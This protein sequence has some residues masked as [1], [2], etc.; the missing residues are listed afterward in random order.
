MAPRHSRGLW[1]I[2]LL[3]WHTTLA[4]QQVRGRAAQAAPPANRRSPMRHG[5]LRGARRFGAA[6]RPCPAA[7]PPAPA[8]IG[9]PQVIAVEGLPWAQQPGQLTVNPGGGQQASDLATCTTGSAPAANAPPVIINN[10]NNNP[11]HDG[12]L[13]EHI[14]K[15]DFA[16]LT[17]TLR[18]LDTP[19]N[20][21]TL[22]NS[23]QIRDNKVSGST[24]AEDARHR[25]AATL[26]VL[27]CNRHAALS[28][29]RGVDGTPGARAAEAAACPPQ[30]A[31]PQPILMRPLTH[32]C[33]C[34]AELCRA[35]RTHAHLQHRASRS[36]TCSRARG[37][38]RSWCW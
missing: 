24:G 25:R 1:V 2:W 16:G 8:H 31:S 37:G 11:T 22:L 38:T 28:V 34:T 10:N 9:T 18:F 6:P 33:D 5:V 4:A 13:H 3:V 23:L 27:A 35:P 36:P 29:R 26:A 21:Q 14:M 12:V 7:A 30:R 32:C 15:A 19:N 20:H 17:E